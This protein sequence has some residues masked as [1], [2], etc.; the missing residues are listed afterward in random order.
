MAESTLHRTRR[1]RNA[2]GVFELRSAGVQ[3][4]VRLV[5]EEL[6]KIAELKESVEVLIRED[7][8]YA[9]SC[10]SILQD[11]RRLEAAAKEKKEALEHA[12]DIVEMLQR[13]NRELME[14]VSRQ[15]GL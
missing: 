15:A 14:Q 3:D 6:L 12:L 2:G 13:R 9:S 1:D 4:A 5:E 7:A 10:H 11:I 8:D